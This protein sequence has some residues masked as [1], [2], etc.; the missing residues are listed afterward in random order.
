MPED[1]AFLGEMLTEN[2]YRVHEN[3]GV[4]APE[5]SNYTRRV[6]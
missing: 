2:G 3:C 4:L 1:P 6:P 5:M